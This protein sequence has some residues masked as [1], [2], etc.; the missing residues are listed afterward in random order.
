MRMFVEGVASCAR[1]STAPN[2]RYGPA[3]IARG[4]AAASAG[5]RNVATAVRSRRFVASKDGKKPDTPCGEWM[6][7]AMSGISPE[8]AV[9]AFGRFTDAVIKE[10]KSG[11]LLEGG[12]DMA[13]DFHNIRRYD[14]KPKPE[15]IRGGD[16]KTMTKAHYETYGTLQCVAAGQRLVVGVLPYLPGQTHAEA[17]EG[18]LGICAGHGLRIKTLTLDRGFYSEAVFSCLQKSGIDWIAP[19]P[20]SLRAKED[21][22]EHA[23]GGRDRVSKTVITGS[24]KKECEYYTVIVPRRAKRKKKEGERYEPWEEYIAFATNNP[25][26]DVAEYDKR[27]G[28]ETGYRQMEDIRAKTRS[29]SH[30]PRVMYV[31]L[32]LMLFNAWILMEALHRLACGI[33]GTKPE[34]PLDSALAALLQELD[35][36]PGPPD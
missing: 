4:V 30:G 23:A 25:E 13:I 9:G 21:V 10:M 19:R 5:N 7:R 36:G 29:R 2:A 27:W 31:A 3:D 15:L 24:D 12:L 28:T 14:K 11:G 33:Q 8:E 35:G 16:K 26:M 17:V 32:T 18:L 20:N 1:F 22:A 34:I 6:R